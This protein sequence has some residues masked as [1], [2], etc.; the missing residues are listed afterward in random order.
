MGTALLS[1][2]LMC[3]SMAVAGD[4]GGAAADAAVAA[5]PGEVQVN[6][7]LVLKVA[8]RDAAADAAIA[9]A[10]ELGG[11]FTNLSS[12]QVVLRVPVGK[13]DALLASASGL[14]FV[15]SRGYS[16]ADL[17]ATL[18]E[19]RSRLN[20]RETVLARYLT[21]LEG[22]HV[23]A[24]VTVEREITSLIG[25]I[26]SLKGSIQLLEAQTSYGT[27]SVNFQFQ[28]RAA[29]A[30]DG[31]SNFPWLN[32]VNLADRLADLRSGRLGERLRGVTVPVPQDFAHYK[33]NRPFRATSADGVLF[34]VRTAKHKPEAT[35]AFWKEALRKRMTDAGYTVVAESDVT[36]SGKPGAMLELAAPMGAQDYSYL[37]AVF[38]HGKKLVL[39]EAAGEVSKFQ[40]R[41]AAILASVAGMGF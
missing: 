18:D 22:A 1:L 19:Q 40:V 16:R 9:R 4:R 23:D 36:A 39:V 6:A 26:E 7:S 34:E 30:R 37:V 24:V 13:V 35:L 27:V 10:K 14:G 25:Q 3:S 33:K 21:V 29:P 20:A 41:K 12:E 8:Q 11:Y 28:D 31:S 32:T 15:V 38:V 2:L 17:S 5:D